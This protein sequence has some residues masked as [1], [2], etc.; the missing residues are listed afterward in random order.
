[1]VKTAAEECEETVQVYPSGNAVERSETHE[2]L[3]AQDEGCRVGDAALLLVVQESVHLNHLAPR[4]GEE[5]KG[6]AELRDQRLRCDR[7]VDGQRDDTQAQRFEVGKAVTVLRQL[8]ETERS[9]VAA[10]ED[11]NVGAL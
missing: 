4:V 10:I 8:T 9:P 1:M 11:E 7:L 6:K 5:R 2:A 3:A